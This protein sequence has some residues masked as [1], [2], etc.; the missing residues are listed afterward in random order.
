M[1]DRHHCAFGFGERSARDRKDKK[2]MDEV[3][4]GE[5][6]LF[7]CVQISYWVSETAVF[8]I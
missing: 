4:H 8:R 7:L 6:S 2:E 1:M 5:T 3:V